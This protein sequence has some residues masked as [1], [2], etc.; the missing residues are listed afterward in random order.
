MAVIGDQMQENTKMGKV[1]GGEG[2]QNK[3]KNSLS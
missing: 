2:G 1:R 3:C